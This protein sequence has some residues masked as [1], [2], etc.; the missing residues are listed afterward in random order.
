MLLAL[1]TPLVMQGVM[2][3]RYQLQVLNGPKSGSPAVLTVTGDNWELDSG[4]TLD[5]VTHRPCRSGR[6]SGGLPSAANPKDFPVTHGA[7]MPAVPG[8]SCVDYAVLFIVG[9]EKEQADL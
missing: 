6:Y 9:L 4:A 7:V 2:K 1:L 8:C 5:D 3:G